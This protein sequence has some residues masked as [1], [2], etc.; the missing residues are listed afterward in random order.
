M[1]LPPLQRAVLSGDELDALFFDV[2]AAAELIEVVPKYGPTT[3][4][5]D[6]RPSLAEARA[7]VRAGE[8]V[9][10]Q[11]RYRHQ[12]K[13]WWDTLM[14]RANGTE[15]VRIEVSREAQGEDG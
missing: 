14:P 8:V 10:V 9:A 3:R 6:A 12:G 11:L 7:L 15:L 13:E 5:S 1:N 4:A 2:E